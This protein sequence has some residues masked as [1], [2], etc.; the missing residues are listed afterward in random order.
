MSTF[1]ELKKNLK[2]DFSSHKKIK[3]AL[4]GD[5]ATQ[6]LKQA[7]R[8]T[9]FEQGFDIDIWEANF[10]Q[11][12]RQV[13]DPSSE[14]F[15][16]NPEVIIIFHSAHKLLD[17]Y[18]KLKLTLQNNLA[19]TQLE[20]VRNIVI[21][22]NSQLKSKI[23]YYNYTEINDSVFGNYANKIESSFL[24]QL[25]KLN[26][27]LM[28]FATKQSSFYICDLSS[29]QNHSGKINLFQPSIYI[30]TEMILKIDILPEVAKKTTDLIGAMTGSFKKCLILDLD[31]TMWGGVIGDD[32]LENIQLG[33]LGIGKSFTEFQ[34]WIKKLK[35]RGIILAVCSKNTESV[36]KEPFQKHPDMV[37]RLDDIAVFVAN[38]G[39]KADN[40]RQ[41]QSILNIGF[42]SMVFLDDNPFERNIVRENINGITV[43]ELPEDPADYLEFLYTLNLFETTSILNEDAERTKRYKVEAERVV[44]Q[45]SF[46]NEDDFLK[47]LN[48]VSFVEPFNKFNTP[49]VA[50]LS[51][52][53]NQF[54][55]RTVRYTEAEIENS[56]VDEN[57]IS[58]TFTLG[59]KF[60]ENGMIC[61][62]I[63]RPEDKDNLFIDTWFMS[64]RVL[65]RG[66]EN[67]VLNTIVNCAKENGYSFLKGEYI[68]TEK[69][70]LVKDH[71][72]QLGFEQASN[73]WILNVNNYQEK[74]CFIKTKYIN[75]T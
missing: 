52:R 46:I 31:N 39:N 70:V 62:I 54:N 42:D 51:Q 16:F 41:I 35:N 55:L 60:G 25:R 47:S 65:K 50:Q 27:E 24:F 53:S 57:I 48:M 69:N 21:I 68:Q 36:A 75:G 1:N 29:I 4:L 30:N 64:C 34:Y 18:N 15:E 8:G 32:G 19:N 61:V 38:W 44:L 5:T 49:R 28:V 6:L 66:M 10:N 59:D 45:K 11:I 17:K 37:L 13:F 3:V 2:K 23:I 7:I 22:I 12:E 56:I 58:F 20:L 72:F 73:H 40:I 43:P 67:F 71:Y 9:G 33:S 14:L 26:F 74:K 63:L